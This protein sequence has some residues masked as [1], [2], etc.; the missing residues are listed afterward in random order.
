MITVLVHQNGRT[1]RLDAVDPAWIGQAGVTLWLDLAGS[2][3]DET[4]LLSDLFHFH[5]LAVEDALAEIH[6]PKV[7]TYGDVIYL[8][9]HAI[10]FTQAQERFVTQDIDFFL[11]RNYLVTVHGAPSRSIEQLQDVCSRANDVLAEGP[12]ML[13]YRIVDAMVDHYRPEV[14]KL[15]ERIEGV[16]EEVF[17]NPRLDMIREVLSLKHDV[18][19]LRRVVLPQR[20]ALGRMAR[21]EF[22]QIPENITYR[23]RDVHDHLVRITDESLLFQDRITSILDAHLSNVSNRLN[24]VVK[25]LTVVATIFMPLTVLTGLYGMNVPLPA[26]PGGEH[27]QFW[28]ILALMFGISGVMLWFF[29]KS[30][31]L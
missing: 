20:D 28:W 27:A 26:F 31:W 13:L 6:H 25:A 10:N 1:T 12:A 16:E 4:R 7:E 15:Q 5:E 24:Q 23:L 29:R 8:I 18:S 2:A 14:E 19:Q 22:P 11:G 17:E 21:R 3:P 9:L 30:R